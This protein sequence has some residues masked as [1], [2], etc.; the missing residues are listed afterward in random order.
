[1]QMRRRHKFAILILCLGVVVYYV[2]PLVFDFRIL[3][4]ALLVFMNPIYCFIFSLLY[5]IRFGIR[6]WFP[7][8]VGLLFLPAALIFY[9]PLYLLYSVAYACI[10]FIGCFL[11]YPIF[12]RYE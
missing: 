5:T 11:G 8:A 6:L 4:M 9:Q 1:M 3:S 12:K 10:A 7:P 2:F